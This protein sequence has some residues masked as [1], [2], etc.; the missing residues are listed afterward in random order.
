MLKLKYNVSITSHIATHIPE[1]TFRNI[2]I[3]WIDEKT[4]TSISQSVGVLW[5]QKAEVGCYF[6]AVFEEGN[7]VIIISERN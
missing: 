3:Q 2:V 6:Q 5:C 1:I 4:N 7:L